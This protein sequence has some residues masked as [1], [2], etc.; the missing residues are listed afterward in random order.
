MLDTPKKLE[1]FTSAM[2]DDAQV[3]LDAILSRVASRRESFLSSAEDALLNEVYT[4]IRE[5]TTKVRTETGKHISQLAFENKRKLHNH[6]TAVMNQ[7]ICKVSAKVLEYSASEKYTDDL[8]KIAL[9][10]DRALGGVALRIYLRPQDMQFV[11]QLQAAEITRAE[12]LEG[13]IVYGGL[14]AESIANHLR[15]DL[16]YDAALRNI[17]EKFAFLTGFGS[18]D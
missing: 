15:I 2:Y 13:R 17:D 10:A 3:E 1:K 18:A 8:V 9:R 7:I 11:P 16:S 4:Y 12:Y 6:R 14:I 5:R